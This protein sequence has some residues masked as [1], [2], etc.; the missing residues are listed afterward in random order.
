MYA[1]DLEVLAAASVLQDPYPHF[2]GDGIL[3]PGTAAKV[4][5][6]FPV[7][8]Q[9]GFFPVSDLNVSGAFED[10]IRD[11]NEPAFSA[12]VGEKLGLELTDKPKLITL[13]H[14][15]AASD[16]RIHTDSLS[17]IATVLIYLNEGWRDLSA[18]RLR[19]L[20]N[21]H[22]FEDYS[23]EI[24]PTLGTF[25]GFRRTENS[26]HGHLP[27]AGERKV[28]QITWL[29]DASKLTHKR[30]TAKIGGWLKALNPFNR[31]GQK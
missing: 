10:L 12:L 27:F 28:L 30:R 7:L 21:N 31:G 13:R 25:F 15:S 17:K 8:K 29:I 19:V 14:W 26:W 3:K 5:A 16:G 23:A 22:D 20:R 24:N 9:T 6:D 11:V 18:G 4:L 1:I 2:I